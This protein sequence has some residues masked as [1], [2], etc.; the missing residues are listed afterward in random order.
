MPDYKAGSGL[1]FIKCDY[2]T[3]GQKNQ[4]CHLIIKCLL[5]KHLLFFRH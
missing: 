1:K 2:I 4:N 3:G 5:N